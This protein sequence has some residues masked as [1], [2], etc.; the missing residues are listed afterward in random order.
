MIRL[1][2]LLMTASVLAETPDFCQQDRRLPLNGSQSCA[3]VAV[4]NS[5][6][7][8]GLWSGDQLSLIEQL[9]RDFQTDA[10]GTAPYQLIAGLERFLKREGHRARVDYRGWRTAQARKSDHAHPNLGEVR[11]ALNRG[12]AAWLNLGWYRQQGSQ[13]IRVGGHWVTVVGSRGMQLLLH[14]PSPRAGQAKRVHAVGFTKL[15]S[16]TLVGEKKGLPRP[17]AGYYRADRGLVHKSGSEAA[18]VDGVVVFSPL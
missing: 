13:Y 3:P 15:I 1:L 10:N 18:I 7:G 6:M 11:T 4:S 5:L 14:D 12:G 2:I 9:S 8:L 16:G 17:A